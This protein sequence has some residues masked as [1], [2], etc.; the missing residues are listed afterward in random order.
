M[1]TSKIP[2]KLSKLLEDEYAA[3]LN[4]DLGEI[5]RLG[6]EKLSLLDGFSHYETSKPGELEVLRG[7][8]IRNQILTQSAIEGMRTAIAR[9]R[10]I[11]SVATELK[12]YHANGKPAALPMVRASKLSKRS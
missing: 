2:E 3:L 4:G 9:A 8:L 12:T 5:A 6:N 11:H 10:E 1:Q 7:K